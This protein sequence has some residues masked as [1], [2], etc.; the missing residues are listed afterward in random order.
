M[1][2]VFLN[3]EI[4]TQ[5]TAVVLIHTWAKYGLEKSTRSKIILRILEAKWL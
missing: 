4:Q 5:L 2:L 1:N 3:I